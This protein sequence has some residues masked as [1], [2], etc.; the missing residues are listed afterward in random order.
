[1][2]AVRCRGVTR[3]FRNGDD[4]A[5]VLRGVDLDVSA[6]EMTLIAGPSG[7][8]KTTLL[9]VITGL[10]APS[11]GEVTVLGQALSRMSG[12][13]MVLFRRRN[14][15]LVSQQFSLLPPLTIAEN[16][17]VPLLAAG[18]RR[19]DAVAR[20]SEI[21][22]SLGLGN[23]LKALPAVLS[24]G[25]QQRVAVAR[26]LVHDPRLV[27]CDEPTS[28]LDGETGEAVM[29]MLLKIAVHP[30]RA[31]LVVTHDQRVFPFADRIAWMNDGSIVRT[32]E[33]RPQTVRN[34]NALA[35]GKRAC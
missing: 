28:A 22:A 24:V 15:G 26:A 21:L 17:A 13:E 32:E 9:S 19:R 33:V 31:I 29:E 5:L 10:L 18:V 2:Q 16:V 6:G 12:A 30:D 7:C 34:A 25:Q 23:R 8:G 27:V 3:E 35:R 11:G 20:A 14:L 1:M 4:R